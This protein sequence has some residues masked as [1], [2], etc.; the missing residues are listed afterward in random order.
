MPIASLFRRYLRDLVFGAVD[1]TVTTFAVV[2]GAVGA[3]LG[4]GIVLVLGV[5]NLI[6]DGFSM[7]VSN[8]LG[9]HADQ[10]QPERRERP[11]DD[12]PDPRG[13]AAATFTAFVTA[14]AIPLL[15][16]AA[17]ALNPRLLA[18]PLAPS[19]IMT[20]L[21][22]VGIGLAKSRATDIPAWRSAAET[23]ALGGGAAALAFVVGWLL[24][25]ATGL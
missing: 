12:D 9:T 17:H 23:L 24:R 22:F 10:R 5:A 18:E 8:Y 7:A 13:A 19:S 16:F 3:D 25:G 20:A 4:G 6:A 1:G 11:R 14:G 15:P 2:A 21:A